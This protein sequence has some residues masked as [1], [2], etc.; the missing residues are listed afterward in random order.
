MEQPVFDTETWDTGLSPVLDL[1][2]ARAILGSGFAV[3]ASGNGALLDVRTG[4]GASDLLGRLPGRRRTMVYEP[5][6]ALLDRARERLA[7]I[8]GLFFKAASPPGLGLAPRVL[9]WAIVA[10]PLPSRGAAALR[11]EQI[12]AFVRVGGRVLVA[13]F[14][15]AGPPPWCDALVDAAW[16]S[17]DPALTQALGEEL[18]GGDDSPTV[19]GYR[20]LEQGQVDVEIPVDPSRALAAQPFFRFTHAQ[21]VRDAARGADAAAWLEAEASRRFDIYFAGQEAGGR[22]TLRWLTLEAE[23]PASVP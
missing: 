7:P 5:D 13:W 19:I 22:A 10:T 23:E 9:D 12:H 18:G 17:S 14:E 21:R 15:G 2:L 3:E 8:P 20:I 4:L 11:A 16:A 1:P 6:L